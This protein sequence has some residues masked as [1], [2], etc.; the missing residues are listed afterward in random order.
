M[1]RRGVNLDGALR[2]AWPIRH[3][4]PR[5][6]FSQPRM[7]LVGDALG[8]DPLFSEGISQALAGGRL[9][10]EAIVDGFRRNDLSFATYRKRVL[11]SRSGR[12][13]RGY[14][15]A[16]RI[17]YGPYSLHVLS[18]LHD[19]A[20]LRDLIG[21]SYAGTANLYDNISRLGSMIIGHLMH[22][23]GRNRSLRTAAARQPEAAQL[24]GAAS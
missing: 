11:R 12:E 3:F 23:R 2:K 18:L 13:L 20:E 8:S 22:L 24:A 19:N 5:D 4:D 6:K 15:K 10:A 9:A 17:L 14:A 7:L 21:H 1:A 16:A